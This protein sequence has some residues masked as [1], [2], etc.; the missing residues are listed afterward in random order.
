MLRKYLF[1]LSGHLGAF[2]TH[3]A[4]FIPRRPTPRGGGD[5]LVGSAC[6]SVRASV[7]VCV[8]V[9]S[10][11]RSSP[12][13]QTHEEA[14]TALVG[15]VSPIASRQLPLRLYQIT[16]KFRDE[17][18]PRFGLLRSVPTRGGGVRGPDTGAPWWWTPDAGRAFMAGL[19]FS[20]CLTQINRYTCLN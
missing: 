9:C 7:R 13:P 3:C 1:T 17:K 6:A 4:S 10:L 2:T 5:M 14:V 15:S 12:A 19:F 18:R 16:S 20:A 8:R 11:L